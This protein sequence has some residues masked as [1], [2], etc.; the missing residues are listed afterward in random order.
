MPFLY[1]IWILILTAQCQCHNTRY[2]SLLHDQCN[3][4]ST[5][6]AHP[7]TW[8][9]VALRLFADLT[10]V[11]LADEDINLILTD[12]NNR[13]ILGNIALQMAPPNGKILNQCLMFFN[14][15]KFVVWLMRTNILGG[16]VPQMTSPDGVLVQ[17]CCNIYHIMGH[18]RTNQILL[19]QSCIQKVALRQRRCKICHILGMTFASKKLF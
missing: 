16:L 5:L 11:T 19:S 4:Q 17:M 18:I 2:K 13:T 10:D 6:W 12:D 9:S 3:I 1:C 14:F 8:M 15:V 7:L